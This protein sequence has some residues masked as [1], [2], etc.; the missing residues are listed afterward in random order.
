M[1]LTRTWLTNDHRGRREISATMVNHDFPSILFY[2][3][4]HALP[5]D[6][7]VAAA[8]R[9]RLAHHEPGARPPG[10]GMSCA[11]A[12]LRIVAVGAAA[13]GLKGNKKPRGSLG[14]ER[15][16]WL[17]DVPRRPPGRRRVTA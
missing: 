13:Q 12:S 10:R 7:H 8:P 6:G 17:G 4:E 15:D 9:A 1:L 3:V 5:L 11:T 16:K 2:C 14:K